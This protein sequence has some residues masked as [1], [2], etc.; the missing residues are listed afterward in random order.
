MAE[1]ATWEDFLKH[2]PA[3]DESMKEDAEQKLLE[4]ELEVLA[5]YPDIPARI[6]TEVL[7]P[8]AVTLVLC[9]MV[10]RAM[11]DLSGGMPN[12]ESVS[13]ST[14]PF[15]GTVSFKTN[16][17]A[18]YLTKADRRLLSAGRESEKAFTI[19]PAVTR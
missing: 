9:R 8:R 1:Y 7:D 11:E 16:D 10:K 13:R 19:H 18:L 14:G 12:V 3:V 4:A 6:E 17:G 2:W 5:L 15:S